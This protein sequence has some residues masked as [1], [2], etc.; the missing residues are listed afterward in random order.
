MQSQGKHKGTFHLLI[1]FITRSFSDRHP[2]ITSTAR[3]PPVLPPLIYKY[4]NP[5]SYDD[6]NMLTTRQVL[7]EKWH[8]FI[9][10]RISWDP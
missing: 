8:E 10:V 7:I 9:D 6:L 5:A 4:T 3:K 1:S 2:K